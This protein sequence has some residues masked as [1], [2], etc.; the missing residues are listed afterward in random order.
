V[1]NER[2]KRKAGEV[3]LE[4]VEVIET[5]E[6]SRTWTTSKTAASRRRLDPTSKNC[7]WCARIVRDSR[8]VV[9]ARDSVRRLE[10]RYNARLVGV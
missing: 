3:M 5:D 9:H 8:I 10:A 6:D 7:C 2:D 4:G 1:Q